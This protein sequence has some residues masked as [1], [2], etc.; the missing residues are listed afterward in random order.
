MKY[1]ILLLLCVTQ[2][3]GAGKRSQD[4]A[5]DLYCARENCYDVLGVENTATKSEIKRAFRQIS[6][7][8]HPDKTKDPKS[9]DIFSAAANAYEILSSVESRENYDY[10]QAH[11]EESLNNMFGYYAQAAKKISV[12]PVFFLL[13]IIISIF[14][15]LANQHQYDAAVSGWKGQDKVQL[16][17]KKEA[18]KV[19]GKQGKISKKQWKINIKIQMDKWMDNQIETGCVAE[20]PTKPTWK[21]MFIIHFLKFPYTMY[22][23]GVWYRG[24][25]RYVRNLFVDLFFLS[26]YTKMVY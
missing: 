17:A 6:I 16:R 12:V 22:E 26:L 21:D 8:H 25:R 19:L 18:V 1:V 7:K 4:G 2:V 13:L 23:Q 5:K 14:K 11:P 15:H 9:P 24:F 3:Q 10:Y 20:F